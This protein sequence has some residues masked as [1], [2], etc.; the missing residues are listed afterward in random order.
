MTRRWQLGSVEDTLPCYV[1]KFI[2]HT[3]MAYLSTYLLTY[4]NIG[5]TATPTGNN[6]Q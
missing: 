3:A 2:L 4:C 5:C 6:H 1:D